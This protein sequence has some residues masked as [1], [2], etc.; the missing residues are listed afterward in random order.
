MGRIKKT[1]LMLL[2]F[3]ILL[4]TGCSK[5]KN[6]M[7]TG[8]ASLNKEPGSDVSKEDPA[9]TGSAGAE[10]NGPK[11]I[12]GKEII[13]Y[14]P[15]WKLGSRNGNVED[16]PWENVTMVNHAFWEVFPLSDENETSFERRA[17][18]RAARTEFGIR[19]TLPENDEIIF[20]KYREYHELYPDVKIL[21]SVGGW[22]R[23]GFF[24]EMAYTE[25]GR[26]G[27]VK[28]CVDLIKE[29]DWISGIDIDWEYPS[30]MRM[31]RDALSL[32]QVSRTG[33][34]SRHCLRN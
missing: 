2:A 7:V 33:S 29:N 11:Y 8:E 34:I 6:D 16:I 9:E 25:E 20:A 12:G 21:I 19:S 22:S 1:L 10:N 27:F 15:N 3:S 32:E 31:T 4:G 26:A 18:G 5:E 13:V 23:C 17:A 28:A 14:Y 30:G 24:S